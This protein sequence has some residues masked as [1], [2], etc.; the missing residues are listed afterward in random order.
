M[1]RVGVTYDDGR[2]ALDAA[3]SLMVSAYLDKKTNRLVIVAINTTTELQEI[4]LD[5][6]LKV[7]GNTFDTYT[8]SETGSLTKGIAPADRISIGSRSIVTLVGTAE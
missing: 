7:S 5:K 8:T 3:T 4:S 1:V 6:A 2:S